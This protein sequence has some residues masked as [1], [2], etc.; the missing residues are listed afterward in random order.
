MGIITARPGRKKNCPDRCKNHKLCMIVLATFC[1]LS[2]GTAG[3]IH[4]TSQEDSKHSA[5]L[6]SQTATTPTVL[7][8]PNSKNTNKSQS[9]IGA[10][11]LDIC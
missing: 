7:L 3:T 6:F 2:P 9:D 8:A 1:A 5:K 4:K 11:S 10:W